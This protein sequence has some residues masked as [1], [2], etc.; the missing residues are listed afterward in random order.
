M[1]IVNGTEYSTYLCSGTLI[2][3]TSV[4][5]SAG[6]VYGKGKEYGF[7]SHE[8]RV[9]LGA[10]NLGDL[11]EPEKQ[12]MLVQSIT[13]HSTWNPLVDNQFTGDIAILVLKK[14]VEF[15]DYIKPVCI[16]SDIYSKSD[17]TVVG[18]RKSE[19]QSHDSSK[20]LPQLINVPI[21][22]KTACFERGTTFARDA[23]EKSFCA[24]KENVSVCNIGP[25][26]GFYVIL[27]GRYYLRGIVSSSLLHDECVNDNFVV[28]TDT[29]KYITFIINSTQD[30]IVVKINSSLDNSGDTNK[31]VAF[32]VQIPFM[33]SGTTFERFFPNW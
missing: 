9:L 32:T 31:S 12:S 22:N 24:G 29:I 25:G 6:C 11:H 4:V 21:F 15:G 26:S 27:N 19:D 3:E 16:S 14:N 5:T 2:S 17:G 33:N 23:W 28:F 20:I 30:E 10:H 1:A 8:L 18:W 7:K 13:T